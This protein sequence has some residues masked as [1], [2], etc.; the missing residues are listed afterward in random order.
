MLP[1]Q[2][3]KRP[4]KLAAAD[5]GTIREQGRQ[6]CQERRS[7]LPLQGASGVDDGGCL[8]RR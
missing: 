2:I 5:L 7:L 1:L 8:G 6:G 4:V 3:P